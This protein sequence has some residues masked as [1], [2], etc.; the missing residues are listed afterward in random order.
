MATPVF[1]PGKSHRER[2]LVGSSV[3]RVHGV[4]ESDATENKHEF[5]NNMLLMQVVSRLVFIFD[6]ICNWIHVCALPYGFRIAIL[7]RL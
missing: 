3:Y 2:S 7:C 1:L 6:S 4:A 5:M